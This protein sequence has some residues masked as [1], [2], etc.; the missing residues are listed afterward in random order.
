MC[1][2]RGL[3]L[4]GTGGGTL[5]RDELVRACKRRQPAANEHAIPA[6]AILIREQHRRAVAIDA[7][8]EPRRR[9]L[10]QR[11]Q[12]VDLGLVGTGDQLWIYDPVTRAVDER[13]FVEPR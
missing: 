2:D 4:V 12:A 11:D 5:R 8:G 7:S 3:Q 6:R 9:E 1:G 13:V 10:E